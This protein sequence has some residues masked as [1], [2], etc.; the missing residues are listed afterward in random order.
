MAQN[1]TMSSELMLSML[2]MKCES[3]GRSVMKRV[4]E[5]E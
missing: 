5:K 3:I 2:W 1:W 4:R